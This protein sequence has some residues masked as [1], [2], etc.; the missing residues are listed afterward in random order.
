MAARLVDEK[1]D[2]L[3]GVEAY[4]HFEI[5]PDASR[6]NW[7]D[8]EKTIDPKTGQ[9]P[10]PEEPHSRLMPRVVVPRAEWPNRVSLPDAR[11]DVHAGRPFRHDRW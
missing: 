5:F 3:S 11:S 4:V 7:R 2:P 8:Q 6:Y 1:G 9:L 10:I